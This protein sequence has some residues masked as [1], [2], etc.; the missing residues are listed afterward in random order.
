MQ[1]HRERSL[2]DKLF[3]RNKLADDDTVSACIEAFIRESIGAQDVQV[4]RR[5]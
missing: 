5:A 3:G 1:I 2:T 4:D